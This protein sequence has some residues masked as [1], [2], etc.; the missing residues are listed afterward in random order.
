MRSS[1]IF[2]ATLL[3]GC[4][5]SQ[6]VTVARFEPNPMLARAALSAPTH[7]DTLTREQIE[8]AIGWGRDVTNYSDHPIALRLG[9]F[10]SGFKAAA[11]RMA[12]AGLQY[13]ALE[14]PRGRIARAAAEHRKRYEPFTADSVTPSMAAPY[15]SILAS[16]A[17]AQYASVDPGFLTVTHIVLIPRT[18]DDN[19]PVQP[20]RE[21][22]AAEGWQNI[23]GATVATGQALEAFFPIGKLPTGDFDV[24]IVTKSDDQPMRY[25]VTAT[26]LAEI[27]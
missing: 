9:A 23:F 26:E 1:L 10:G 11:L 12:G 6:P 7:R 17:T 2:G 13:V 24:V 25:K 15:L 21:V 27:L 8:A 5:A 14:G 18:G 19:R 4:G 3:V 22:T 16:S 20:A